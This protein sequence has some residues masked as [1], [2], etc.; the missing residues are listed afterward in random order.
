MS[1][2]KPKTINEWV[3]EAHQLSK[4]KGWYDGGER[5]IGEMIALIHSEASE[6][7]E[8]VR[9][10]KSLTEVYYNEG[11]KKPEGFGVE[12]ADVVIRIMDLCKYTGV[13]LEKMIELKHAY[14]KTRPHKH[15]NKKF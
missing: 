14:N 10:G 12:I 9:S 3:E 8:E 6:A 5:N 7:L 2:N 11:S 15:G 13:D 4:S 1:E